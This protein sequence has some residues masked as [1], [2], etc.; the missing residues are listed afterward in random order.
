MKKTATITTSLPIN[1]VPLKCIVTVEPHSGIILD[2]EKL[3]YFASALR[4]G[5]KL[6]PVRLARA[7]DRLILIG[8][9]HQ[10]V[11]AM[12]AGCKGISATIED[13]YEQIAFGKAM[14]A[15]IEECK[16]PDHEH[17]DDVAAYIGDEGRKPTQSEAH[18]WLPT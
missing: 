15:V 8:G 2:G 3:D 1:L 16:L 13:M 6:P 12:E 4:A 11:A 18:A 9:W 7:S 17:F 5:D 14:K 10:M